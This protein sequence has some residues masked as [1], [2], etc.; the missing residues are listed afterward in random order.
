MTERVELKRIP[1]NAE[2]M[3]LSYA[4][5]NAIAKDIQTI[6][7][8]DFTAIGIS[9]SDARSIADPRS[10]SLVNEQVK[11][12]AATADNT[13]YAWMHTN[14]SEDPIGVVKVGPHTL[15][16]QRPYGRIN[17]LAYR[18]AL[19]AGIYPPAEGLHV[20]AMAKGMRDLARRG[21]TAVYMDQEVVRRSD[22]LELRAS[23]DVADKELNDAFD[24]WGA[25][26]SFTVGRIP[27]GNTKRAY[28]QR[29]LPAKPK[30]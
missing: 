26:R 4:R 16:D 27:L 14:N 11:R 25:Y 23:V 7:F 24:D 20:F 13:A 2:F 8:E 5:Q 18:A 22:G 9:E 12:L 3:D 21:L 6:V 19:S 28:V 29:I 1:T 15:G 17:T 30:K 10:S